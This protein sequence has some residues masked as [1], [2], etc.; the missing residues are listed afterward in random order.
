MQVYATGRT[1]CKLDVRAVAV[2][3]LNAMLYATVI[4][5]INYYELQK[6]Y[7]ED[8]LFVMGTIV[9]T[10]M[11]MAL[12]AKVAFLHHQWAW[13]Q[14]TMMAISVFGMLLYFLFVDEVFIDYRGVAYTVY[15]MG[16]FWMVA[17]FLVPM[18]VVMVD[19]VG[20]YAQMI[21][22]PTNEM[23]YRELEHKVPPPAAA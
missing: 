1:N 9:F 19:A 2:W 8:G 17:M 11:V 16:L 10:G 18:A 3:I 5:L 12:Q 4:C 13:P 15:G 20:Y 6:S 21:F 22:R 7:E 14:L 23:L